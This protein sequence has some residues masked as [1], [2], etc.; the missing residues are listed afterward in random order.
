MKLWMRRKIRRI[1]RRSPWQA[2][3]ECLEQRALLTAP[4]IAPIG[5]VT[6]AL[7]FQGLVQTVSVSDIDNVPA[8]T[9]PTTLTARL[10]DGGLLP[11]WLIFSSAPGSEV[12][13]FFSTGPGTGVIG[14]IDVKVTATDTTAAT[15]I[16][17][18]TISA[19][20]ASLFVSSANVNH[21][22]G[23]HTPFSLDVSGTFTD[24]T[25]D[26]ITL[27][28]TQ[29]DG[30]VLPAWLKFNPTTG[31]FTGTPLDADIGA[32]DV[33]VTGTTPDQAAAIDIFS[34]VVP[35]NHTPEFVKGSDQVQIV[36]GNPQSISVT[37][38]AT[39][40]YEG[41]PE[42]YA[43]TLNFIVTTDNAALFSVLPSISIDET[44]RDPGTNE[45]KG[46]LTYTL[47]AGANGTANVTVKLKDNGGGVDTSDAQTFVVTVATSNSALVTLTTPIANQV[48]GVHTLLTLPADGTFTGAAH[49]LSATLSNGNP[50]PA[51]LTF[52]PGAAGSGTGTFSGTPLDADVGS[53]NVTLTATDGVGATVTDTF[54]VTVPL[55]H[56]PQFTKG[57]DQVQ[58]LTGNA[59]SFTVVDWASNILEGP[60]EEYA[61]TLNFI[62]TTD[63]DAL[64][65]V[66]PSISIDETQSHPLK[67]TL[68]YTLAAGASGTA[69]VTVKLKDN[70]GGTDTSDPQTFVIAV[71]TT[72]NPALTVIN[73]IPNQL[74][75][76]HTP[77]TLALANV[78]NDSNGD[79]ITLSASRSG[80]TQLNNNLL[81]PTAL[82][83]WLI[84]TPGAAGSGTG[85]FTGIPADIDVGTLDVT[86]TA[87]ANGA[88]A[89]NT[90]TI[91]VPIN[92]TPQFTKGPDQLVNEDTATTAVGWATNILAGPPEEAAQMLD[93]IVSNNNNG[94][95]SVQPTIA[96]D[97]TLSFTPA[98]NIVGV[99][100]V[101]VQLHDNGGTALFG[102]DTS[103][104]QTFTIT[105]GAV[106]DA[107]SFTKGADQT[108]LEDAAS[109]TVAGWATN[110]S[111]GPNEA[112]QKVSFVVTT[113]ND[114]LFSVLPAVASDG[115]LTYKPAANANGFAI[116]T[117]TAMDD[118][119]ILNGGV[120]AS[121]PQTFKISVTAV[122]DVPSFLVGP[123]QLPLEGAGAQSIFPWATAIS[124]GPADEIGQTL[125]FIVTTSNDALFSV[126]PAVAV[127]GRLTYTLLPDANGPITVTVSLHD[128]GGTLNGGVDTSAPQTFLI[129]ATG[130]NDPPSFTKGADQSIL[131]DAGPQ[132][133]LG[134]AKNINPGPNEAGQTVNFLISTSNNAFFSTLPVVATD[135]TLTYTVANNISGV[136]TVMVT[137]K[138][139]GGV[140]N[141]GVD[142]SA[143]QTFTITVTSV[144]DAPIFTINPDPN[145]ANP[146]VL[147]TAGPQTFPGWASVSP[148]SADEAGQKLNFI[149]TV[150]NPG[151]F[152][153]LPTIGADGTLR[154]TPLKGFGGTATITVK[155]HDNGGTANGG[156]DTSVAQTITITTYL[157]D[158]TYSAVGSQ[159]LRAVVVN[160]LLNVTT[161]GIANS[162]YLPAFIQTLT[163]NGGSSDDLVN[164]SGLDPTLYPNL[165]SI[166][167]NGGAGKDA[168][169][170][171]AIG[172]A[173]FTKLDTL[174]FNGGDGNDLINLTGLPATLFPILA[175]PV[176]NG[177]AG[178]DTIFGS[179]M[180]DLIT[181]GL[182]NDSLNGEGGTDRLV[183]SANASFK[184]TDTKLTGVGTDKLANFE[185]ASLTGGSGANKLDASL[186]TG[187]VTLNGGAGNDTLI[188]GFGN[189][190]LVG[191]DGNDSLVGGAGADTLIGGL[192]N[193]TLKGG[194][195]DDLLIGGG[196]VDSLDG[197]AGTDTGLGGQ[198]ASGAPRFGTGAKDIGD[199]LTSIETI[200]EAFA[201]LFLFE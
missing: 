194:E 62:V 141:G 163:L 71:T 36:S 158:V 9:D 130:V 92:H 140:L 121:A 182:G 55:N 124:A 136:V 74:V 187:N 166:I 64:F 6:P 190:A 94:L 5:D 19:F 45:L 53:I 118:G 157:A 4:I 16:D 113:S 29:A 125:N 120:N 153:V 151:L 161:G 63:N 179:E 21:T 58:M 178:N 156:I 106:N 183:E 109:Q 72:T 111:A 38:W 30:T 175:N 131:E 134:W 188:G 96:A 165:R 89:T 127:N 60:P 27:S 139:N 20:D 200:N 97:G 57:A 198:G 14:S 59:Q 87:T 47:A 148:G 180:N 195:G 24:T 50:L 66:P 76:I 31:L 69:N 93:F 25:P 10:A 77:F 44:T 8:G 12:G 164:L 132:S 103:D 41:P 135:G 126:L 142:T 146:K 143:P 184:L 116:V 112:I 145:I 154:F 73:P 104:A 191:G 98:P 70:G 95:F 100:T 15:D 86:V 185:E 2:M 82:P 147:L 160:G 168:I 42:E 128:N 65:S 99:A 138:D 67:G 177:G 170:F 68:K 169:T 155:L 199:V 43:Q 32:F 85:T 189:D 101:T 133:V 167:V 40:I 37:D 88:T 46:K 171:N 18:F 48:V 11:D 13:S 186:F 174:K 152:K 39:K 78:F 33:K 115:T 35:L 54:T 193:D 176:L 173:P 7:H 172:T 75:G 108:V 84:F 79:P 56:T 3:L 51:W 34:I 61:Q 181:G 144:N 197:G 80:G 102:D 196:G 149:V 122:N 90:F 49:T 81:F 150:D 52:T 114:A 26:P 162:G 91:N 119:G 105:V 107:P 137:A 110:I 123:D 28:A 1:V 117:V 159:K 129:N 192:G 201:T 17:T 23:V 22:V 83:A